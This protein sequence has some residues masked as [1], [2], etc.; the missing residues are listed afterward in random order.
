MPPFSVLISVYHKEN[1]E[2]LRL[3]LESIW[4]QQTLKPS[5]IVLVCDGPLTEVLY[6][7]IRIF[8]VDAPLK[9]YNLEKHSGLGVALS[10]GLDICSNELIA[11]MD[12]D[13]I[14]IPERFEKQIGYLSEHPG[15]DILG[16]GIAEFKTSSEHICSFRRLPLEFEELIFFAKRRNPLNHVTVVFRKSA[17]MKAGNYQSFNGYEDYHLWVRMLMKGSVIAN[18]PEN[19]VLVRI[20]NKMYSRRHGLKLFI[21]ELKLLKEFLDIKFFS[22]A[23]YLKNLIF[24]AIP[25]LFPLWGIKLVYK[26]LHR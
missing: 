21:Q 25:R 26:I 6:E 3:A 2:Y 1:P 18:I 14:S 8:K 12:G 22:Y 16:A 15:I 19:L 20:G 13:D 5:E 9:V 23:D 24:R 7:V 10:K 11:R 17:V 4:F